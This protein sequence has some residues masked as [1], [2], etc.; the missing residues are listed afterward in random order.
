MSK[1]IGGVIIS[2][3]ISPTDTTDTYATHK[4]ELGQGGYRTVD[5]I[6]ERDSITLERR[7]VG[8]L[9]Y[10]SGTN[11]LY[12]LEGG[13]A[14]TNWKEYAIT[15]YELAVIKGFVGTEAQWLNTLKGIDGKSAYEIALV[16]GYTGTESQW[17]ASLK[18]IDGKSAYE[19][20]VLKGYTGTE[21]QWVTSLKG[22]TGPAGAT[23]KS[24]YQIAV[25]NGYIGTEAEWILK[26]NNV[27][28]ETQLMD[29]IT[30]TS[31]DEA[32]VI[33]VVNSKL[34]N[35]LP[36][37]GGKMTGAITAIREMY[38]PVTAMDIDTSL[39]NVFSK[40]VTGLTTFTF[41][42]VLPAPAVT[43]FI[44]EITNGGTNVTWPVGVRWAGGTKPILTTTGTDL[45]GFYS[46]DGGRYWRGI[47][48][49]KDSK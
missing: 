7:K 26:L 12:R 11:K 40:T 3:Y 45:L 20:A 28:N 2:G 15:A 13:I 37:S 21:A 24:A 18:G 1:Y 14:N 49:S 36:L 42:K 31:M 43:S 5:S 9:V 47:V 48:L 32:E 35:Y 19:L 4:E 16:H 33:N 22:L 10:I 39:G 23:G 38:S 41:S 30:K 44:I 29:L 27:L 6:M 8:M 25:D 17:I 46:Y 34:G